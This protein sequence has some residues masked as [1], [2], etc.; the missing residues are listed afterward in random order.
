MRL[1]QSVLESV[2]ENFPYIK[3][4]VKKELE[5]RMGKPRPHIRWS[6]V[7]KRQIPKETVLLGLEVE[8]SKIDRHETFDSEGAHHVLPGHQHNDL[9]VLG[10]VDSDLDLEREGEIMSKETNTLLDTHPDLVKPARRYS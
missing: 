1:S 3:L 2:L 6:M 9:S 4:R 7:L 8:V 10:D 5:E